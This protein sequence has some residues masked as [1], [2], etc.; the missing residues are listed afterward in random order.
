MRGEGQWLGLRGEG[1]GLCGTDAGLMVWQVMLWQV[2]LL[3]AYFLELSLLEVE[4]AGWEPSRCAAAALS[5]ARRVLHVAGSGLEP[6]LYR[7]GHR[8]TPLSP[9]PLAA[10]GSAF[11][12]L[13]FTVSESEKQLLAGG[14]V[15]RAR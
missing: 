2:M 8:G 14:G 13:V 1:R 7:Y 4:A 15:G 3:A 9:P 10:S 12:V 6:A 11:L 5:L